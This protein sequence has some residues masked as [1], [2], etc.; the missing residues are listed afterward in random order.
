[1]SISYTIA[2]RPARGFTLVELMIVVAIIGI[3]AAVA[4]P[5]YYQSVRKARRADAKA[6]LMDL[7]QREERYQSTANTYTNSAPALGYGTGTTVTSASPMNVLSGSRAY[8]TMAVT[9]ATATAFS[10]TATPIS[11]TDQNKDT[12]CGAFTI[13]NTGAQTVSGSGSPADCW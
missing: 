2:R 9:S 1:M 7:A 13:T 12:Q 4:F 5:A 10:A 3:L 8:Y 11:T 6:A